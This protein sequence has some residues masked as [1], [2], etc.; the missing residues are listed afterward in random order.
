MSNLCK[1]CKHYRDG[2]VC[3][4][5]KNRKGYTSALDSSRNCWEAPDPLDGNDSVFSQQAPEP[6]A[7]KSLRM[8]DAEIKVEKTAEGVKVSA[9]YLEPAGPPTKKCKVCGK[10]LPLSEF[11][12]HPKSKDGH[13][14]TCSYCHAESVRAGQ[15][16][17]EKVAA[18]RR[19][20]ELA[21][22][23]EQKPIAVP[24]PAEIVEVPE[25]PAPENGGEGAPQGGVTIRYFPDDVLIAEMRRR[26]LSVNL[27][28]CSTN[29]LFD[30]LMHRPF[31]SVTI[32][33]VLKHISDGD[34]RAEIEKRGLMKKE[35]VYALSERQQLWFKET[36]GMIVSN[37]VDEEIGDRNS[38]KIA[39]LIGAISIFRIMADTLNVKLK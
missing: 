29:D 23:H 32:E 1:E 28:D 6:D 25:A 24:E 9:E 33:E 5:S 30:E 22:E 12:F 14:A 36:Y 2:G 8:N 4:S 38:E 26:A 10:V 3:V 19:K 34:L 16:S 7:G 27:E 15:A 17:S 11:P 18:K 35:T 13:T 31:S 37:L 21:K 20:K 39:R